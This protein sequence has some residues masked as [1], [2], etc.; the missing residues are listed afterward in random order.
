MPVFSARIA[1]DFDSVGIEAR[2]NYGLTTVGKEITAGGTT[3]LVSDGKNSNIS[4]YLA[5]KLN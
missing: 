5:L 2:Y 1:F 4:V 3:Y